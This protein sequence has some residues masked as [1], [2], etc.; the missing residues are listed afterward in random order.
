MQFATQ[1]IKVKGKGGYSFHR[2]GDTTWKT[3]GKGIPFEVT[4]H[5]SV[6]AAA[7]DMNERN[8]SGAGGA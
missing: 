5:A 3:D 2:Q 6:A 8:Q 4:K 1:H 7:K